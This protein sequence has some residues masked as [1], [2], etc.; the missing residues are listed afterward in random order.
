MRICVVCDCLRAP[1]LAP[2]CARFLFIFCHSWQK[3][4]WSSHHP[5][6]YHCSSLSRRVFR[7]L[8]Q[9]A[10]FSATDCFRATKRWANC[11][12]QRIVSHKSWGRP[13]A[14]GVTPSSPPL[15]TPS[16]QL[17]SS[18]RSRRGAPSTSRTLSPSSS[19]APTLP[20]PNHTFI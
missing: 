18:G 10:F 9:C 8:L 6:H 2:Q 5:S 4:K 3:H 13:S 16:H 12:V 1:F 19:T 20:T 7:C 11:R 17:V 14:V 15:S